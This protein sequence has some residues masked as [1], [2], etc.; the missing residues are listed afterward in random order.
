MLQKNIIIISLILVLGLA[1]IVA[2]NTFK[3][4]NQ[5][6]STT[7]NMQSTSAKTT[8]FDFETIASVQNLKIRLDQNKP[9]EILLDVRTPEEFIQGHIENAVNLD[10][11]NPNFNSQINKLDKS[12]TYIVFCRSGS[13]ALT[14]SKTMAE[15][16]LKVIYSKE[17]IIDWIEKG[18]EVVN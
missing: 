18:F 11:Q 5:D 7:I 4:N 15:N 6:N 14:A 16:G 13:R 17:G 1:S 9:N 10:S 2:L 12:K 8:T 3:P